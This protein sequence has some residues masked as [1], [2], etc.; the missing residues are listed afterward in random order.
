MTTYIRFSETDGRQI[1]TVTAEEK[2]NSSFYVAPKSFDPSNV[3]QRVDGVISVV[4]QA[5]L[6]AEIL[7][8][9]KSDALF[10]L[11]QM[12]EA[13]RLKYITPG[14]GKSMEYREVKEEAFAYLDD[15]TGQY[16]LLEVDAALG[17]ITVAET[18]E[19]VR[20]KAN[21]MKLLA[22]HI[23]QLTG[24]AKLAIATAPDF[25]GVEAALDIDWTPPTP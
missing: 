12:A 8:H 17:G 4:D 2:P 21:E 11:D 6:D 18:A 14:D 19:I 25:A 23:K 24:Q 16:P 3:Y 10:R 15:P 22:A 9:V 13:E 5:T 20:S 1:E 7:A